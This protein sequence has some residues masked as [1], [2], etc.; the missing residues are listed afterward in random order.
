[1]PRLYLYYD[2]C[3]IV[4]Y[5]INELGGIIV[6]FIIWL[7]VTVLVIYFILVFNKFVHLKNQ[8]SNVYSSTDAILKKRYDLIPA[9][10]SVVQ[11]YAL[12]EEKL[13]REIAEIRARATEIKNADDIVDLDSQV[14]STINNISMVAES[15]PE[16][17]ANQNFLHL[18]KTL[19]EVEEQLSAARRAYNAAVAQYNNAVLMF[20]SN[21]V[22]ALFGYRKKKMFEIKEV[23]RENQQV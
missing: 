7:A 13:F 23:E 12:H 8:I 6:T 20:P 3:N 22:A 17:N 5:T 18:Q 19:N 9:L 10:V 21:I 11:A 2:Y 14:T 1:M 16:L 15:Y 4:K